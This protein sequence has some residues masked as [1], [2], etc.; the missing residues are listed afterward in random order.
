M[1]KVLLLCALVAASFAGLSGANQYPRW[2][3][4]EKYTFERWVRDAN[5]QYKKGTPEWSRR[6]ELFNNR[7]QDI[8][9]HNAD[10]TKT[11]KRGVNQFSDWTQAEWHS[12]NRARP[13]GRKSTLPEYAL[14]RQAANNGPSDLPNTVDYRFRTNPPILTGIK[15]QGSCGSCWAHSA[16]E[17]I[18]SFFALR[19][20]Q[21]PVL[22]VQQVTSCT[23][24]ESGCGGGSAVAGWEA[25]QQFGGINEEWTYPYVD[26]FA[27]QMEQQYTQA[28]Q[29]I[30]KKFPQIP[31]GDGTNF[32]FTWWPKANVS[33]FW[34]PE[35]NSA[36]AMME[37]LAL[38]GPQGVT[39]SS[40]PWPDY[41][42]GI[43]QNDYSNN[44]TWQSL[45]HDVQMVGYGYDFD[46]NL[47]YWVV[48]NSW[49]TNYGEQ[50]YIRLLRPE[51]EPCGNLTGSVICGTSGVLVNPVFP[52]VEP[53]D[54]QNGYYF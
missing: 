41:E 35:S 34:R 48:R 2:H 27:P 10:P 8:K 16:T 17:E 21:L 31:N 26:F 42:S 40:D 4:L 45:D 23:V 32:T 36:R 24:T 5:R 28:C 50:G 38:H 11:W 51:T 30:T 44:I 3:Q 12:Y 20:G 19:F 39:V 49:G 7:F 9:K 53:L 46:L 22:S 25:V 13:L 37:A 33:A 52:E 15:N 29:N 54:V 1:S 6:E 18:E 43:L 14:G 47:N